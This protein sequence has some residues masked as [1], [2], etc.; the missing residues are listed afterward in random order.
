MSSNIKNKLIRH[1]AILAVAVLIICLRS[2]LHLLSP[3]IYA[4]EPGYYL[5]NALNKPWPQSFGQTMVGYFSI[6]PNLAAELAARVIPLRYAAH[7][8]TY[9]GLLIQ[10]LTVSA[11]YNS[12]GRLFPTKKLALISSLAVLAIAKPETWLNTVYSMYWLAAGMFCILNSRRISV[13]QIAY[14][15]I[16]FLTGPTS[17]MWLPFFGLRWLI[18]YDASTKREGRV[19]VVTLIGI[20]SLVINSWLVIWYSA[21]SSVGSRLRV[22]MLSNLPRGFASMFGHLIAS[23]GYPT[24]M[25]YIAATIIATLLVVQLRNADWRFRI[26][27]I[28]AL[29]YYSFA[30]ALLSFE[31]VGGNRYALPVTL[32][33]FA[34]SMLSIYNCVHSERAIKKSTKLCV[35]L[36]LST[37]IIGNRLVEFKDFT[38]FYSASNYVYDRTWPTWWSQ[39]DSIDRTQGGYIKTFPQWGESGLPGGDWGFKLPANAG[40]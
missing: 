33:I 31:M 32:G 23:G 22:E 15:S 17:L 8:F 5:L 30:A 36:I 37:I 1:S 40:R 6:I 2:P 7:V 10:L 27:T 39:I 18:G 19:L 12:Q 3:R 29:I 16:A 24:A 26:Y 21:D 25:V 34:L 9:T 4:E 11:I 14:S 20:T 35:I 38:G 28:G 13:Y